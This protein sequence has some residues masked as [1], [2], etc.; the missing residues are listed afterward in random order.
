MLMSAEA[1]SWLTNTAR[2]GGAAR[3]L[4]AATAEPEAEQKAEEQQEE[5]HPS[6][7]FGGIWS[8]RDRAHTLEF[9]FLDPACPDETLDYNFLPRVQWRKAEGEIVLLYDAL[10]VTVV[11]RGLNLWELKE[12]IRQH[13]VTWVQEQGDDP[14]MVRRGREEAKADG[15][16]FV[17]V[18]EIR[19]EEQERREGGDHS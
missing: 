17:L 18:Q 15:R 14:L 11:I 2:S 3:V 4:P 6:R 8:R 9:R 19:W 13:L 5:D 7:A 16:D 1:K 12:R 10:G